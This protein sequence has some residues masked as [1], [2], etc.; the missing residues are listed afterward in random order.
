MGFMLILILCDVCLK[1]KIYPI[2]VKMAYSET[3]LM[4]SGISEIL[5]KPPTLP[6]MRLFLVVT[7]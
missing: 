5:A 7:L 4:Y 1:E 2:C 6:A 3:F